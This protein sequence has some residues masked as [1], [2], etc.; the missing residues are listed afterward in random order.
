[1]PISK[2]KGEKKNDFINRCI[3][4]EVSSG[5][6]TNQAVAVC[7]SYW[8]EL[9]LKELKKK[10][11]ESKMEETFMLET[12]SK[13]IGED[14]TKLGLTFEDLLNPKNQA[15]LVSDDELFLDFSRIPN[16]YEV[17]YK[18]TSNEYGTTG[19]SDKSRPFCKM[20]MTTE[21]DTWFSREQIEELNTEPGKANRAGGK[22]YSVFN[23]RG[24]NYCKHIWIRYY[25]KVDLSVS[26][27]EFLQE[28]DIGGPSGLIQKST[29]PK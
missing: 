1:M 16:G 9:S 6:K 22:A 14:Y 27:P 12:F 17:R 24:G 23:W 21:R 26:G 13:G 3:G 11:K 10:R 25:Y 15:G 20:M 8:T 28:G 19:Y 7:N 18:Y 4:V 5:M 29:I 2:K